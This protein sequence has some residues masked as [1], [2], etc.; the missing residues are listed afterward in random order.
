M[1]ILEAISPT[2]RELLGQEF[3][4]VSYTWNDRHLGELAGSSVITGVDADAA[5]KSFR[6]KH[7]HLTSARIVN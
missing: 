1:S 4:P 3:F 2:A 7:P 6:S 5:L